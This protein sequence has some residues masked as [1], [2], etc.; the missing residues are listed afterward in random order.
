MLL[1][2]IGAVLFFSVHSLSIVNEPLRDKMVS[3]VGTGP[4]KGIYSLLSVLSLTL[5]V[6]GYGLARNEPVPIWSPPVWSGHL[7]LLLMIPVFPLLL[8]T[9]FPGKIKQAVNHPTLLAVK[10]WALA[11][12]LA[13]G[14]L[15]DAI[16]FGSFLLWAVIDR[17]SLKKR[18]PRPIP[19][20]PTSKLNDLIA[21]ALGLIFYLIFALWLHLWLIGVAP[22][23]V[24]R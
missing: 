22:F 10:L 23:A 7:T 24:S 12:L 16:L 4:F 2:V 9:Y 1:L 20:V 14:M 19:A 11:H 17:I 6:W 5:M 8:A 13:N 18:T 15:A 21:V 3:K